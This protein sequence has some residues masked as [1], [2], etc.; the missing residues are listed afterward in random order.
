MK[1]KKPFVCIGAVN[2]NGEKMTSECLKTLLKITKYPNY[3]MIV[4]DNGSVDGSY[5]KLKKKFPK[6]DIIKSE[7]NSGYTGGMNFLWNYC[8][9]NYDPDYIC[10][11]NNDIITIQP[12]WLDLLV[13]E[14]EKDPKYG[15]V[16]NLSL[17]PGKRL[18]KMFWKSEPM[19]VTERNR[20]L[21][22]FVGE[23]P[24]IGGAVLLI[25][26][27]VIDKIG[28]NDE[29]YFFGPDD[30]DYALRAKAA[31]FKLLYC[32]KS[33]SIHVSSFSS[34]SSKKDFIYKHQS[35][36]QLIFN[37]RHGTKKQIVSMIAQQFMRIFVAKKRPLEVISLKN[38][39]F[40]KSFL[41]RAFYFLQSLIT[42]IKSYKRVK[43]GDYP[44][45]KKQ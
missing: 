10:N 37:F 13:K 27:S 6:V 14:L 43:I 4:V 45:L 33:R 38:F 18:Q 32:G 24:L 23:I 20:G 36:G 35:C 41:R 19:D 21:P 40:H 42:A 15:I 31:G 34:S 9:N 12:E 2:Y 5:E 1:D 16:G 44:I 3:K 7:K 25:K 11:I 29:N 39:Y 8:L 26:R 28:G 22:T 30:I 17:L